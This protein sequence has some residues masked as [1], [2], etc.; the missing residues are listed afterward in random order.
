MQQNGNETLEQTK[1]NIKQKLSEFSRTGKRGRARRGCGWRANRIEQEQDFS[2]VCNAHPPK[3]V[4]L[5]L[6]LPSSSLNLPL[7]RRRPCPSSVSKL[8]CAAISPAI[9]VFPPLV[10]DIVPIVPFFFR[11]F[12][13]AVC[14]FR[15]PDPLPQTRPVTLFPFFFLFFKKMHYIYFFKNN[16]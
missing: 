6:S 15:E 10:G 13:S 4:F 9:L 8:R 2:I 1:K 12:V 16:R 11:C 7:S 5:L 3:V 14:G